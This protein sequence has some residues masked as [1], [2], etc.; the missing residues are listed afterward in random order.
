MTRGFLLGKFM[1]PH[2]GHVQLWEGASRLV[3]ELTILVCWLPDD[4]IPGTLRMEWVNDL[5][6]NARV[7]GFG[8]VV[9][10]EP[11]ESPDFWTVW[12]K[13]V[14]SVHP[15][16]IDLLFAG[17]RYGAELACHVGGRFVGLGGRIMEAD[18]AGIGSVSA[19]AI[20]TDPWRYR[21]W[22]PGPVRAFYSWTVCL[23]G[24]ESTGK[25]TLAE[26]LARH[27]DT[28][29]AAEYGRI[30]CEVHGADCTRE[31][32]LL[33]GRAQQGLIEASKPWCNRLVITDTDALMTAAWSEMMIS[34]IPDELLEFEKADLYLLLEPDVPWID[35]GTRMYGGDER[36]RFHQIAAA[37]LE[38]S[39]V[40]FATV[41]GNWDQR[42]ERSIQLIAQFLPHGP[43]YFPRSY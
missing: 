22:L 36:T 27:F 8:E 20:R 41:G 10:Q 6:P 19:T 2:A 25:S 29:A 15:E 37:I 30:H 4:P 5:A 12:R 11:E 33:I 3:D 1:P 42:F 14:K 32:L 39:G 34:E 31:D 23:H 35:D 24:V 13:I 38:R 17:E 7:V 9:P 40:R 26:R 43:E 28:V 16:P 18:R 21:R